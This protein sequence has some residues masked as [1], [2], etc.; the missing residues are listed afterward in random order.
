[1]QAGPEFRGVMKVKKIGGKHLRKNPVKG[2]SKE[3]MEEDLQNATRKFLN[4][5]GMIRKLPEQKTGGNRMVGIKMGYAG[6]E[7]DRSQ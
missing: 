6:I 1:M 5:G 3:F 4:S 7:S 2:E